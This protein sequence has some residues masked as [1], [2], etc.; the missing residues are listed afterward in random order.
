ML[1]YIY[2]YPW[3]IT[4]EQLE[5]DGRIVYGTRML[6]PRYHLNLLQS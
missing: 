1:A 4:K 3:N 2:L 6:T 5:R